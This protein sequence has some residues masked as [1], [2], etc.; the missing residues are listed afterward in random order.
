M[1]LRSKGYTGQ[2]QQDG[3]F[4]ASEA[5]DITPKENAQTRMVAWQKE[6][7]SRS[8]VLGR[9]PM[10]LT[11]TLGVALKIAT[12]PSPRIKTVLKMEAALLS[13]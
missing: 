10:H 7:R 3:P 6:L 1:A 11:L 8:S 2:S 9:R 12:S 5:H 4:S 13:H